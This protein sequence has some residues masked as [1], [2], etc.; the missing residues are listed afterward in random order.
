VIDGGKTSGDA[1]LGFMSKRTVLSLLLL[2]IAMLSVNIP[3]VAGQTCRKPLSLLELVH[4]SDMVAV[5]QKKGF[6]SKP[7]LVRGTLRSYFDF[8]ILKVLKPFVGEKPDLSQ[9]HKVYPYKADYRRLRGAREYL[10]FLSY[11]RPGV[12]ETRNCRYFDITDG[13][14]VR[15]ICTA[16]E[17]LFSDTLY[18]REQKCLLNAS[19]AAPLGDVELEIL[20][21]LP[22]DGPFSGVV[23]MTQAVR[24]NEKRDFQ[25]IKFEVLP[26][27]RKRFFGANYLKRSVESQALV[28]SGTYS[29]RELEKLSREGKRV[30]IEGFWEKGNFLIAR[31]E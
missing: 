17:D 16:V 14:L 30:K 15:Q 21:Y 9:V 2:S 7:A 26:K 28:R 27:D 11:I 20:K 25:K 3:L 12:W 1:F 19:G 4:T 29:K 5:V 13:K 31:M 18:K 10:L 23:R 22:K 8:H 24:W 6:F